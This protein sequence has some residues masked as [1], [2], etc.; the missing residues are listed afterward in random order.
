MCSKEL[1]ELALRVLKAWTYSELPSF[2]DIE[3]LRR[4]CLPEESEVPIDDLACRVVTR[5]CRK[6]IQDSQTKRKSI[7]SNTVHYRKKAS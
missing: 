6:I 7:G 3:I 2:S 4:S 5:E 1:C